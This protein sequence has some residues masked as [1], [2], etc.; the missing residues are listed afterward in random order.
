MRLLIICLLILGMG[1]M[2]A[3]FVR[4]DSGYVLIGYGSYTVESS[5]LLLLMVL[6]A[7]FVVFYT[8]LRLLYN[9]IAAPKRLRNWRAKHSANRA[10]NLLNRGLQ[11]LSEGD[12]KQAEKHLLSQADHSDTPLLNYLAAARSAQQQEAYDRRDHYLQLAHI[13]VPS[14]DVAV[15]LTQAELQLAHN[16]S[17]QALAT[18]QHLREIAPRHTHVLKLLKTLY[19]QLEDW[20][21]LHDLLPELRKRKVIEAEEMQ[22]LEISIFKGLLNLAASEDDDD[23]LLRAWDGIPRDLKADESL[24]ACYADHMVARGK[25][26]RALTHISQAIDKQWSQRLIELYG[27]TEAS[28]IR[29]QLSTAEGWIDRKPG[30]AVMLLTLGRLCLRCKLWGKARTY[31]ESSISHD[32]TSAAAYR[33]LG[34]LLEQLGEQDKAMESYR[35]GLE[36]H[37]DNPTLKLQP[38]KEPVV[39]EALPPAEQQLIAKTAAAV[40]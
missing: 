19:Q 24:V 28:D 18:L 16:Q 38:A 21:Q 11:E 2:G 6:G 10:R 7:L 4:E 8:G 26:D 23:Q 30:D 5:L 15:G 9:I 17:E 29:K 32:S 33:E 27:Q 31:L 37:I 36:L 25:N 34:A 39:K 13:N 20:Q 3:L 14:A 12:W 22:T 1:A 35:S 40:A